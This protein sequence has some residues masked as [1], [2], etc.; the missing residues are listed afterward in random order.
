MKMKTRKGGLFKRKKQTSISKIAAEPLRQTAKK[1]YSLTFGRTHMSSM[2]NSETFMGKQMSIYSESLKE[3]ANKCFDLAKRCEQVK[4]ACLSSPQT[5]KSTLAQEKG[6]VVSMKETIIRLAKAMP[7]IDDMKIKS[8]KTS[9]IFKGKIY[10]KKRDASDMKLEDLKFLFRLRLLLTKWGQEINES[11]EFK[12]LFSYSEIIDNDEKIRKE[13]EELKSRFEKAYASDYLP[14]E[15]GE[16]S[17]AVSEALAQQENTSTTSS[18][19][20]EEIEKIK[21][22]FKEKKSYKLNKYTLKKME[23]G[24]YI[25]EDGAAAKAKA[26]AESAKADEEKKRLEEAA[27]VKKEQEEAAAAN[28]ATQATAAAAQAEQAKAELETAKQEATREIEEG[29]AAVAVGTK[30]KKDEAILNQAEAE[31]KQAEAEL[32]VADSV[33]KAQ[34]VKKK[35]IE[36]KEKALNSKPT[37]ENGPETPV[38]PAGANVAATQVVAAPADESKT[39]PPVSEEEKKKKKEELTA[40]ITEAKTKRDNAKTKADAA[41]AAATSKEASEQQKTEAAAAKAELAAADKEMADLEEEFKKID[42]KS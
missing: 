8:N 30:E 17:L 6:Y 12:N 4:T 9:S 41:D 5:C 33:E 24:I 1:G 18:I 22:A 40:K 15:T 34:E 29:K 36:A 38:A 11:S 26:K 7:K 13:A 10:T 28:A 16:M 2:A 25:E 35:A 39:M 42:T 21:T 23:H 3:I 31:L 32:T 27:K 37:V 20:P 14:F 19:S